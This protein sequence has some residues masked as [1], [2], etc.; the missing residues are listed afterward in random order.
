MEDALKWWGNLTYYRQDL[1]ADKHCWST[2]EKMTS[3]SILFIYNNEFYG[4]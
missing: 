1:L 4:Y 2:V 3:E